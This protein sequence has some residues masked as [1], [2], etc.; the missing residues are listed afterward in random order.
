MKKYLSA[1]FRIRSAKPLLLAMLVMINGA[2]NLLP[3]QGINEQVT[4][5]AAYE[6]SIPDV[7]KININPAA[8]ETEVKLPVMSYSVT[9]RKSVV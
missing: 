4:V 2:W 7:N 1:K 3:G 6:P 8:S 9:D 5:V